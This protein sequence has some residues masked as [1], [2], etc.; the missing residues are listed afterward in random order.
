M[1]SVSL[2][3][4][5][6]CAVL[7][8]FR[9]IGWDPVLYW[10]STIR[11]QAAIK[12][13]RNGSHNNTDIEDNCSRVPGAARNSALAISLTAPRDWTKEALNINVLGQKENSRNLQHTTE[14]LGQWFVGRRTTDDDVPFMASHRQNR[15]K[16]RLSA[17]TIGVKKIKSK[18]YP[19]LR[20]KA[21]QARHLIHFALELA[22][23]YRHTAGGE[24]RFQMMH[25]LSLMYDFATKTEL[26][27]DDLKMWRWSSSLFMYYYVSCGYRV[28][29]KFYYLLH[30]PEHVQRGAPCALSG[31]TQRRARI[32]SWSGCSFGAEKT[33]MCISRSCCGCSGR[34]PWSACPE[35]F[36][37]RITS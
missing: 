31:F 11:K 9:Q 28:Y 18:R 30:I 7:V 25:H 21:A 13:E 6:C 27:H 2:L 37:D 35:D 36:S 8:A 22:R 5:A 34:E 3:G 15:S 16:T 14:G 12:Y 17:K 4:E 26:S 10:W 33:I 29:P 32:A 19:K 20:A 23:E 1:G 24:D